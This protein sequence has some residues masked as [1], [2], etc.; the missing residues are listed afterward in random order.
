MNTKQVFYIR[1][2]A[3]EGSITAAA[4]ALYIS[5]PALSQTLRQI[6]T[7]LGVQLFDREAQ[8]MRPTYAGEKYLEYA[9][10]VLA[11]NDRLERQMQEIRE[12]NGGRL[13]LGI[14]VQRAMQILP[15][16]MPW[17]V[18]QFPNVSIDLTE[19][20]SARLDEMV[21]Q[22]RVD[23]ALAALESTSPRID[24]TLI[25]RETIGI[26]AGSGSELAAR[27]PDGSALTIADVRG[28][29]FVSLRHG[30]SIRVVQDALFRRYGVEPKIL[31]ETDSLEVAKRVTL[32]CGACML[33]S[34]IYVDDAVRRNGSFFPLRDYVNNRHFYACRRKNDRLPRYADAFVQIVT[35]VLQEKKQYG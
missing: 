22:G 14:S 21:D 4:K 7:E 17:F 1:T 11:A 29:S 15:E 33:C 23:L 3:R 20:G 25:E 9:D 5:Q 35:R 27:F 16:A 13:R 34:D 26:L 28:D 2:I 6:E 18:M 12:E 8:P 32:G 10:T 24:Y 19:A 30:H 31:L